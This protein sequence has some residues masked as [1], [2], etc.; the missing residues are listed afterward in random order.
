MAKK[1]ELLQGTLDLL[2]LKMLAQEPSHGYAIAQK[3][4]LTSRQVLDVQQGSLYPALH[5][6][7]RKG[8]VSSEWREGESG[9]MA[10][11]YSLK[12]AGRKQLEAEIK[13][14]SRYI[15]AIQWV[16]EA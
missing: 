12:K 15:S 13:E 10:R 2:V 9:R 6:L 14:W 3:I 1:S 4:L 16:L 5:R 8:F 7:E 11:V